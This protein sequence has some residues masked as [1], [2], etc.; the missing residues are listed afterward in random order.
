M[1]E[2]HAFHADAAII[3]RLGRQLVAKQGTALIELVKNAYDADATNVTVSFDGRGGPG[4]SIEITDNGTGMTRSDLLDGFL[5]LASEAKAQQPT[6]PKFKRNRAG[7]KGIG[8]F[9]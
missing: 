7:R 9:S 8:R 5:R 4:A 1:S 3:A 6:S 2:N